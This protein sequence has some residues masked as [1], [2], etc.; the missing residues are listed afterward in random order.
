MM[1]RLPMRSLAAT[2]LAATLLTGLTGCMGWSPAAVPA[3]AAAA[4]AGG[5]ALRKPSRVVVWHAG[6]RTELEGARWLGDTL[7]GRPLAAVDSP[8]AGELRLARATIDS[9]RVRRLRPVATFAAAAGTVA[10]VGAAAFL[11]VFIAFITCNC[12]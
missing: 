2:L 9:L 10:G 3:P 1:P 4:E 7:V 11:A 6:R 5:A 12:D 8:R